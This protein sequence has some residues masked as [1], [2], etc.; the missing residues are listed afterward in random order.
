MAAYLRRRGYSGL[1]WIVAC[2]TLGGTVYK[3]GLDDAEI[4][5]LE[6]MMGHKYNATTGMETGVALT[7]DGTVALGHVIAGI[8]CG[9]FNRDTSVSSVEFWFSTKYN[10]DNL[11]FSTLSGDIAQT[12]LAYNSFKTEYCLFGQAGKWDNPSCPD[13]YRTKT[14]SLKSKMTDA[15]VLGDIDGFIL[16]TIMPMIKNKNWKLGQIIFKYYKTDGVKVGGRVFSSAKRAETLGE[17]VSDV[18]LTAQS[19]AYAQ[20]YFGSHSGSYG[21]ASLADL[22]KEIPSAVQAFYEKYIPCEIVM[23]NK[24]TILYFVKLVK[25]LEK[26]TKFGIKDMTQAILLTASDGSHKYTDGFV[27]YVQK[28]I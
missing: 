4:T 22:L 3:T 25:K 2:G 1:N 10:L 18:E 28:W 15:E 14:N 21:D 12:T 9:G 19:Y 26:E 13:I 24:Y 27:W 23:K 11:F 6:T 20:V 7:R 16:G 17:L 8:D 5:I